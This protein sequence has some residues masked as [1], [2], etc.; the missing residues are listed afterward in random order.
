MKA[1]SSVKDESPSLSSQ[2]KPFET[3]SRNDSGDQDKG[4]VLQR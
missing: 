3:R 2:L 4:I 1:S